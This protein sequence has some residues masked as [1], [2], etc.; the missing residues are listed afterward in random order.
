[1]SRQA[2]T[3]HVTPEEYLT[4]ERA[5]EYKSEYLDGEIFAMVGASRKHN[6]IAGNVFASLK[7]LLRDKPCETYISDMRVRIPAANVYTYPDVAVVCGESQFEDEAVDTLLNPTL[8]VEV[9]SKSTASYDRTA[10]FGYYRT[11][12]SVTEYLLVAQNDY[13]VE[14]YAKQ[15]DSR[16]LL[17]DIRGLESRVELASVGCT[18][19]LSEV[20]D[21]VG[22]D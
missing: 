15:A 1:M 6:L 4:L 11:L 10:K 22:L 8:I 18:L 20:Y 16:W 3:T 12:A 17:A 14:H 21:R 7:Q 13:H 9:L 19:A 5:A 2:K